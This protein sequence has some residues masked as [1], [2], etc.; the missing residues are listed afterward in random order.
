LGLEA[1]SQH[2]RGYVELGVGEQ[3][4]MLAG[5]RYRF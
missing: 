4:V 2:L 3:G 1:G 5:V